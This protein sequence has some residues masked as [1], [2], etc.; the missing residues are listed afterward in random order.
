LSTAGPLIGLSFGL[1]YDLVHG[2]LTSP[3]SS[4]IR[5]PLRERMGN[6]MPSTLKGTIISATLAILFL[7]DGGFYCLP[8][9]PTYRIKVLTDYGKY[10]KSV[11]QNMYYGGRRCDFQNKDN[12]ILQEDR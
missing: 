10:G 6:A 2:L 8:P 4:E 7:K 1:V 11:R 12:F 9:S 5:K 3:L